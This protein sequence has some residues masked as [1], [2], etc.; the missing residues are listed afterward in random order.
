MTP[1][2]GTIITHNEEAHIAAAILSLACCDE[3]L[4]VD[5]ESTDRTCEIAR[6]CGARVIVRRWEGYSAQKNFAAAEA[7]Y[8]WILSLDAD[9]RV[10]VELSGEIIAW[11]DVPAAS[12]AASMPRRVFYLGLWIRHSG[13]YPD[14]KI[15]LYDRR[16]A[17]WEGAYVHERL[18]VDGTIQLFNGA[19]LHFPFRSW[20][21]Q[22][23]RADRYTR[24]A[25]ESARS[26]NDRGSWIRLIA[27]PAISFV[28]AYI[29]RA[30]FLDGW[31]GAAISYAAARY[32]FLRELRILR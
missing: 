11:R 6:K 25:A 9:E 22:M 18:A 27:S 1:I 19:L 31:R 14:R 12:S 28:R 8:D 29:F 32:V 13:W 10:S 17:R 7:K 15:R 5:S 30:G 23:E 21:D 20:K 3:V 4:V 2:T 16:H 26:Q 24:L